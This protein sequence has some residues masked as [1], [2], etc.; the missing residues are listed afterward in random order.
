MA[1]AVNPNGNPYAGGGKFAAGIPTSGPTGSFAGAN[2]GATLLGGVQGSTPMI[3]RPSRGSNV[4][5]PYARVRRSGRC[6]L[7]SNVS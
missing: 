6:A 4:T 1:M 7:Q 3:A 5:I 2:V